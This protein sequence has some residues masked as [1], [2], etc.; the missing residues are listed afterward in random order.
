MAYKRPTITSLR[1]RIAELDE[2]HRCAVGLARHAYETR[3][4]AQAELKYIRSML[5][6]DSIALEPRLRKVDMRSTDGERVMEDVPS[7]PLPVSPM[8][9]GIDEMYVR[10]RPLHQVIMDCDPDRLRRRTHI[11]LKFADGVARYAIS[12]YTLLDTHPDNLV[13]LL[14]RNVLPAMLDM[15]LSQRDR[16]RG[17]RAA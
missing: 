3:D 16:V 14:A 7:A 11:N 4:A 13:K 5:P 15:I 10:A 17:K 8:A 1:K 9:A 12:D 2:A 6:E